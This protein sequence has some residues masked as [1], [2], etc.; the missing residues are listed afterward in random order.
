M[1]RLIREYQERTGESY[2]DIAKR[3]GLPKATVGQYVAKPLTA[4]PKP[5]SL[6]KLAAGMRAD[7]TTVTR[8]AQQ[9]AGYHVAEVDTPDGT[10]IL[11]SHFEQLSPDQQASVSALVEHLLKQHRD[12]H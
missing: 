5:E 8:A 9:A 1:A 11:I 4:M 2:A 12:T 10:R 6:Q 7:I 3:G